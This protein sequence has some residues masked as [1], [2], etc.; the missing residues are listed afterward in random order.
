MA[1]NTMHTFADLRIVHRTIATNDAFRGVL[2]SY[3]L[4]TPDAVMYR[5]RTA[6]QFA[7]GDTVTLRGQVFAYR[8][9]ARRTITIITRCSVLAYRPYDVAA[10]IAQ[11][12]IVAGITSAAQ[13]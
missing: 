1:T 4:V 11:S 13:S 3:L 6:K 9:R 8:V 10:A 12:S 5:W 7:V 2:W